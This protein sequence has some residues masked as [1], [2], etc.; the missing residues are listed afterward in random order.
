MKKTYILLIALVLMTVS[1]S[2]KKSGSDGGAPGPVPTGTTP[3]PPPTG[4]VPTAPTYTSG[5]T[6]DLSIDMSVYDDYTGR[7]PNSPSNFKINVDLRAA[8]TVRVNSGMVVSSGGTLQN[9]Y[10]GSIKISYQEKDSS[11]NPVYYQGTFQS[12][13]STNEARYNR[14]V[15]QGSGTWFKAMFEDIMG[16][17]VLVVD[18][19]DEF[20]RW[21]GK[22]YFKNFQCG[23]NAWDPPCNPE[24]PRRCWLV[25]AGP[26]DC[27]AFKIGG[28]Q[29]DPYDS[30]YIIWK[31]NMSSQEYPEG[32]TLLGTFSGMDS[33]KALN[34]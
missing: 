28:T 4:S 6:A 30:N 31:V 12:G 26:Y 29:H 9:V 17:L 27:T 7:L 11:G 34:N 23:R 1:C 18:S 22:V 16:G 8:G 20:G 19:I 32:Y 25:S 14:F 13:S 5:A 33:T 3:P 15:T 21:N 24:R 2:E 10:G